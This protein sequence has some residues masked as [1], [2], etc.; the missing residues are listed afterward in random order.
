[1]DVK[2]AAF[3]WDF[4]A[5]HFAVEAFE[6]VQIAALSRRHQHDHSPAL[7]EWEPAVVEVIAIERDQCPPKLLREAIVFAVT[8]TP[9]FIM[10]DDK[11]HV[12]MEGLT[13]VPHEASRHVRVNINARLLLNTLDV[14]AKF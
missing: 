8:R 14:R 9:Q 5:E 4:G 10:L 11:E 3:E 12:P 2:L 1:V 7:V 13:H 6:Q